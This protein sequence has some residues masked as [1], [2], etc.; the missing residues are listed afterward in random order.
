MNSNTIKSLYIQKIIDLVGYNGFELRV[1]DFSPLLRLDIDEFD[2][3]ETRLSKY[4]NFDNDQ[5]NNCI[6][7]TGSMSIKL[8][9]LIVLTIFE[10]KLRSIIN[11]IKIQRCF[12]AFLKSKKTTINFLV[13]QLDTRIDDRNIIKKILKST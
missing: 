5:S 2:T 6:R 13:K 12:R 8:P 9:N 11:I 4:E 7:R 1:D 10:Y 3:Y